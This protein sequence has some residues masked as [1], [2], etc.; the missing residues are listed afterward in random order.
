MNAVVY[1]HGKG[2]SSSESEFFRSF[3]QDADVFGLDY[4][5]S[6]PWE[7]GK[8]I[9]SSIAE[10]SKSYSN[11]TVIAN[12]IGAYFCM[13]AELNLLVK[14]AF[15]ISPIVDMERLI[16]QMMKKEKVDEQELK[17]KG[18][19]AT[20][21]GE[22]LSWHYLCYVRSHPIN[23]RVPTEILY[24]RQDEITEYMTISEFAAQTGSGVTVMQNGE[25]Y[26]H[27]EE[28]MAFLSRWIR[29]RL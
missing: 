3:F 27:T 12:S 25:H 18:V 23:W 7:S 1:V 2:G 21:F 19:I 4:K 11:I 6:T 16:S 13:N 22:N 9:H 26:F 29:S 5:G 15:F 28:Q 17:R 14:R 24:G 8:D 20:E 10:L